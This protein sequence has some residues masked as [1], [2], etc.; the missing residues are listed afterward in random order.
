MKTIHNF[1]PA[2]EAFRQHLFALDDVLSLP[3]A[4]WDVYW[5]HV[6]NIWSKKK[7]NTAEGRQTAY[8]LCRLHSTKDWEPAE[9][10][11]ANRQRQKTCRIA[12]GCG[13]KMRVIFRMEE[14][15]VEVERHGDCQQHCHTLE[16]SVRMK[17]NSACRSLAAS[18][19]AEGYAV[20]AVLRNL[21][22]VDRPKERPLLKQAGSHWLSLKG[23]HN[24]GAAYRSRIRILDDEKVWR[25]GSNN[26]GRLKNG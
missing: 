22:T 3:K 12:I 13:M 10:T 24:A 8:F 11:V 19:V 17:Q 5:P 1:T 20:A 7:T 16:D 18:E 15:M 23:C 9:R 2:I 6:D 25:N 21:S 4:E 26:N 14:R